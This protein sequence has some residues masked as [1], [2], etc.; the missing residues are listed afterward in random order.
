MK[1]KYSA[2]GTIFCKELA[3]FFGDKRMALSTILLPGLMIYLL[4]SLMGSALASNFSADDSVP[5]RVA[6]LHP[7]ESVTALATAAGLQPYAITEEEWPDV[8]EAVAAK[9]LPLC[10]ELPADF[11]AAVAAYRA[12]DGGA[13]PQ[14]TVCYNSADTDSLAAWQTLCAA[15]DAWESTLVNKFDINAGAGPYDLASQADTTGDI[16][17]SLLPMLLLIFMFTGCMALAPESIAGEKERGTIAALLITPAPRS[18]IVFGKIAALSLLSLLSGTS[19][20]VGTILSMPKL[21][22]AAGDGMLDAGVYGVGDYL[23]L[24]CVILSTMLLMVTAISIISTFARTVKEAG[25]YVSPLMLLCMVAGI[26]AMFGSGAS[27]NAAVYLVPLY[28]S[29]QCMVGIFSFSLSGGCF[30]VCLAANLLYTALGVFLLTRMFNN[31][32]VMFSR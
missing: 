2:V 25:S 3:R 10:V 29:V 18:H 17:S 21:M 27:A 23:R 9:Q 7:T 20:A 28:N 5:A 12:E 15:L 13:A 22:G 4:Y 14:L 31:E 1:K 30:A 24:G 19:S 11:D 26:T 32:R 6:L 8:R 16:F